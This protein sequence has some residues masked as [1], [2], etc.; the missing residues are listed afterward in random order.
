MNEGWFKIDD[1]VFAAALQGED[2]DQLRLSV[3]R[4]PGGG[5]DWIVWSSRV[6]PRYGT[7]ASRDVAMVA[8]EEAAA[9]IGGS[10]TS[11]P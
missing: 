10:V 9:I 1:R 8:A 5:W 2:G 4:M 3:E 11:G 6:E 7:A